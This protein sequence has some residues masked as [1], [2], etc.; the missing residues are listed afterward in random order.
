MCGIYGSTKIYDHSILLKKLN[1]INFRGPDNSGIVNYDNKVVFGHNRLSII[2]LDYRSNQPYSY[3][4]INIVYNGEVYNYLELKEELVRLGYVFSTTSDT[5]VVC[6]SYLRWGVDCLQKFNGMFSFVIYDEQNN[7]LFG[8]RDRL[9]KKPLYY[10]YNNE[11]FEFASQP[12]QLAIANKLSINE[13][14]ISQFL[15]WHYV[16]DPDSIYNDVK[17]L[18]AGYYFV[19]DLAIKS[20]NIN[21]YWDLNTTNG[22]NTD[23]SYD[24]CKLTLKNLLLDATSKR[25]NSDVPIGVFLSGGIDSS[26]ITALAQ[27]QSDN[28]I[29]TFCVKFNEKGFDESS[30]AE[31]IAAHLGTDHITIPCRYEEGISLIENFHYFYDEPFGD[32]SAIPMMLLAK[33][34]RQFVTVALS[35]DGGDEG[36]LGY[37]RYQWTKK[38]ELSQIVPHELRKILSSFLKLFQNK[39]SNSIGN[40]LYMDS[41]TEIYKRIVSTTN[42]EILIDPSVS[43]IHEYGNWLS[44]GKNLLERIS[45]Y[46]IKSYLNND[47]NTKVDRATMAFSLESRAPLMDYRIIDFSRIIPTEYKFTKGIKKK[48][49][50]DIAFDFIPKELLERP[51]M[52]FGMPLKNWFRNELKDYVYDNITDINLKKIPNLN[53]DFVKKAIKLHMQGKIDNNVLIWDLLVLLQWLGREISY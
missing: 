23:L 52:G 53:I 13:T 3:L 36:F 46:D 19:Y 5:E 12:S 20:L 10:N 45:D 30:F 28:P 22:I 25:M 11:F 16:P 44:P 2:D 41:V 35:G 1:R 24:E 4:H 40:V 47:I 43:E 34:T 15:V 37:D 51:K 31:K 32:G 7:K 26:L 49:L 6:A 18:K 27:C 42:L 9:G 39:R 33:H 29:K 50:K 14:A 17:K 21:K 8:A 38:F 48:I